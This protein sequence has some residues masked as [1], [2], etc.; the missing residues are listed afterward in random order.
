MASL[1]ELRKHLASVEMT[2]QMAGAMKTAAAVKFS[3]VSAVMETFSAYASACSALRERFGAALGTVLPPA[4]PTAPPCYV[5]LGANRGL[6]GGYNIELYDYADRILSEAG[7]RILI[8][9]G[10][11]A[12][13]HF[14][15]RGEE[16]EAVFDLPDAPEP[17]DAEPILNAALTLFREGRASS[18]ILIWPRSPPP[19]SCCRLTK[20]AGGREEETL[21]PS[22]C[23]C[24]T[25]RPSSSLPPRPASG[26]NFSPGSSRPQPGIRPRP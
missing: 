9:A 12:V 22:P 18:V 14:R 23:I 15:E 24:R 3:R 19:S 2:G 16:P 20:P 7:D 13:S 5:T 10:R 21:R 11:H 17:S 26:R 6:C 25:G 4:D 8:A 1:R